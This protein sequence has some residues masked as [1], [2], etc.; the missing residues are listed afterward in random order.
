M[1]RENPAPLRRCSDCAN[2][3]MRGLVSMCMLG[4]PPTGET[5]AFWKRG[6]REDCGPDAKLFASRLSPTGDV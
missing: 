1:G 4:P 6:W 5:L 2:H 3:R